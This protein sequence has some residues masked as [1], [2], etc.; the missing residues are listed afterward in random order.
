MT[1]IC[2][3]LAAQVFYNLTAGVLRAVGNSKIPLYFL[4]VASVLNIGLDLLF[5]LPFG[6]GVAGAAWATVLAQGVSDVLCFVYIWRRY[7]VLRLTKSDF[8]WHKEYA[9]KELS[10]GV[11]M[12]LQYAI[13]SVGML[14]IQTAVNHLGTTAITAYSVGNKIEVILEQGP[15]AIGSAMATY[16]AQ[17]RGAGEWG[18]VRQGV[19]SA[20]GVMLVYAAVFGTLT[21]MLG[22]HLTHLFLSENVAMVIGDVDVFLKIVS[23]TI[24]LLGVLCVYRNCVQGLGYGTISML[25]GVVEL[26]ARGAVAVAAIGFGEFWVACTGYPIA[27]LSA[28]VLFVIVY[29]VVIRRKF[30]Q[31]C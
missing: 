5:I 4:I 7:P 29:A 2:I 11:P 24:F 8:V 15:I 23:A 26:L 30:S 22:K 28:S 20:L 16:T 1:I 10:V 3:C 25:G 9:K 27:W 21:A 19:R 31:M 12:A 13:T 18:R 6:W 17:N 14:M